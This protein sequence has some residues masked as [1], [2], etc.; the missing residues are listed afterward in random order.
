MNTVQLS[1][2]EQAE[3][4]ELYHSFGSNDVSAMEYTSHYGRTLLHDAASRCSPNIVRYLVAKGANLYSLDGIGRT[5][6]QCAVGSNENLD[7]TK[8]LLSKQEGGMDYTN[9]PFTLLHLAARN[10]NVEIIKFVASKG[11]ERNVNAKDVDGSTPLHWAASNRNVEV[12]KFLVSLGADAKIRNKDGKTPLDKARDW[13]RTFADMDNKETV[14]NP[15]VSK[16]L[17]GIR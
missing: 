15:E 11:Q 14:V 9:N 4:N 17:S 3:L 8:F 2:A 6:L 13:E 16:Y 5:P 1:T 10:E 7:V 12:A